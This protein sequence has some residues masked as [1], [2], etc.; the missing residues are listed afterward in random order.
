[1]P[2]TCEMGLSFVNSCICYACQAHDIYQ[3]L[4]YSVDFKP[5]GEIWNLLSEAVLSKYSFIWNKT[6][7]NILNACKA[8]K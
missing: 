3:V 1:M 8:Q 5:P 7:V 2:K 4:S 6:H